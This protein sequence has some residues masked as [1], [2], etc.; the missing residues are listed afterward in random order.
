M[1]RLFDDNGVAFIDKI[2]YYDISALHKI[3]ISGSLLAEQG[4]K[5]IEEAEA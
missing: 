5:I 4:F 3:K 2:N 1:I